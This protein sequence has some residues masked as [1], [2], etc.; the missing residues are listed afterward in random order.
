MSEMNQPSQMPAG[1]IQ[2][3][4]VFFGVLTGGY[5]AVG[6]CSVISGAFVLIAWV[7][8]CSSLAPSCSPNR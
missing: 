5:A 2:G 7:A 3:L 8:S 1:P 6:L 4:I